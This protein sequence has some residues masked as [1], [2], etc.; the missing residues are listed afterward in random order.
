MA[1]K[2]TARKKHVRVANEGGRAIA[3]SPGMIKRKSTRK[4]WV[5]SVIDPG[6]WYGVILGAAGLVCAC[7]G[8]RNGAA[9]FQHTVAVDIALGRAWDRAKG[10]LA[11][12]THIAP[13]KRCHHCP[14]KRFVKYGKRR[15]T[16]AGPDRDRSSVECWG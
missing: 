4:W 12:M 10:M 2:A 16:K 3:D 13:Q 1:S 11:R 9:L 6:L 14:A 15:N 8:S 5:A 7:P